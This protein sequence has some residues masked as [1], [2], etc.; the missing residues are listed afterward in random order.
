[1]KKYVL[2]LV[3]ALGISAM[4]TAQNYIGKTKEQITTILD[5]KGID[6]HTYY[7]NDGNIGIYYESDIEKRVYVINVEGYCSWYAALSNDEGF[8]YNMRRY[9]VT[10]QFIQSK[11]SDR[12]MYTYKKANHEILIGSVTDELREDSE[13]MF[14]GWNYFL[15]YNVR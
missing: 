8:V 1:M 4:T 6:Y 3:V 5:S 11:V 14:Y 2:L 10:K 15:I 7:T 9:A 12:Y 13:S